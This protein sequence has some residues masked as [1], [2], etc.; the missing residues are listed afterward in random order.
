MKRPKTG[1]PER[2][3]RELYQS[4]PERADA[5]IFGRRTGPSRRGFLK[6]AGLAAMSAAL[7]STIPFHRFLPGGLPPVALAQQEGEE[8]SIPGKTPELSVLNDFP[9]SA[10][11]PAHL[12]DD[13][14]TPFERLFVRNN[15]R[16]PTEIDLDSWQLTIDGEAVPK[17]ASYSMQQLRSEFEHHTYHLQL[18]CAGNGRSEFFPP[19]SGN[20]WTI[21]AV[22]CPE[23]TGVRLREVLERSG[24]DLEKA[25]YVGYYGLDQHSNPETDA[26]P[27]SRG[28]PIQKAMLDETL[29]AW[30]MNGKPL[31]MA[32]GY[33]LR[34]IAG[35]WP[36]S[37]SGKWLG[38]LSI[39]DREHD[40]P[41]MTGMS[42]R[43]PCKPVAAGTEVPPGR[44]CIIESMPVKSLITQPKSGLVVEAQKQ[45]PVAGHAWAG[46]LAVA[47]VH[48]SIDFGASWTKTQLGAAKNRLGWQRF[49]GSVRFPATGYY[50]VWARAIDSEG[51]SQPMV[52]PG[53]NPR[54]YLNNACHRIAVRVA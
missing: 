16:P 9:V 29:L 30:G 15:G 19:A 51:S 47:E 31:S 11:L 33:P 17:P 14:I 1:R 36:G 21:G 8:F 35:G 39:R 52:V 22:G 23:W 18:E 45:L 27:I 49:E 41:K 54:G 4:E 26:P 28:I 42:Y 24:V 10:E 6:G 13:F 34:L 53:W 25:V 5:L 20:Q 38:R 44:M 43:V 37:V 40:G 12:L 7:G 3:L 46:E 2:G 48:L 32:H 50:E